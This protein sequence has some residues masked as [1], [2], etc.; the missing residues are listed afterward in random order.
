MCSLWRKHNETFYKTL[1]D[2]HLLIL[3]FLQLNLRSQNLCKHI[4]QER[5]SESY[6]T[7]HCSL[8]KSQGNK[9]YFSSVKM[10]I[11]FMMNNHIY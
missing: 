9:T 1:S 4:V 10:E 7:C 8:L 6:K 5:I 3:S 11:M 2:E